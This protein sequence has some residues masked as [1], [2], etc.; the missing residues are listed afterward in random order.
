M[1]LTD[2]T[3]KIIKATVPIIEENEAELTKKIYPL[4]FTRNPTMK[5]FFNR[6]HLRKGTQPRAFIGSIIEYAN[7]FLLMMLISQMALLKTPLKMALQVYFLKHQNPL[8]LIRF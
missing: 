4:L 3:K 7:L 5:I 8:K 1:N 2:E 6:D